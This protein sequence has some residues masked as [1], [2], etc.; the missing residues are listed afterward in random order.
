MQD[1]EGAAK[2]MKTWM[3]AKQAASY[4]GMSQ[5][6]F[7]KLAKT[8]PDI[9]EYRISERRVRYYRGDLDEWM[10]SRASKI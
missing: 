4:V 1:I 9:V 2:E 5:D 6:E 7:R 8:T 10:F 3:T